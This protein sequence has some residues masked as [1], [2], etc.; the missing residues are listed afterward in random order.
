[1]FE[2][3]LTLTYFFQELPPTCFPP[4]LFY[5][6]VKCASVMSSECCMCCLGMVTNAPFCQLEHAQKSLLCVPLGMSA[7]IIKC[8]TPPPPTRIVVFFLCK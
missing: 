4:P 6:S 2:Y 1:M 3:I 8:I 5:F 7:I